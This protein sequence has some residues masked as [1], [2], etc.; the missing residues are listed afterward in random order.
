MST[1]S[2]WNISSSLFFSV[3]DAWFC[4]PTTHQQQRNKIE[5]K[6]ISLKLLKNR[7][8][9]CR[10]VVKT[11]RTSH[12]PM[13]PYFI[14][15]LSI[16]FSLSWPHKK[17]GTKNQIYVYIVQHILWSWNIMMYSVFMRMI[18]YSVRTWI[19]LNTNIIEIDSKR[20][21]LIISVFF[22][23]VSCIYWKTQVSIIKTDRQWIDWYLLRIWCEFRNEWK[24]FE[25][26]QFVMLQWKSLDAYEV[27][28]PF[29][30]VCMRMSYDLFPLISLVALSHIDANANEPF[31]ITR[32]NRGYSSNFMS[33]K[34]EYTATIVLCSLISKHFC[35][36]LGFALESGSHCITN[37]PFNYIVNT[38]VS[39]SMILMHI[40]TYTH[41]LI[42]PHMR[43]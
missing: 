33:V 24:F 2:L 30:F 28:A 29:L 31:W 42:L 13:P 12:E 18:G 36:V 15:T 14:H 27:H 1:H 19:F 38:R 10:N 32:P 8:I 35:F 37:Q 26:I 41:T 40:C 4:A 43:T 21:L 34:A 3:V 5:I 20:W 17:N 39:M 23:S 22:F 25:F 11:R 9:E 6:N 7:R 16:P